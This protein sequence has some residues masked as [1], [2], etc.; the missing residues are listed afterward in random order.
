[1]A[2]DIDG[3]R[4]EE[5]PASQSQFARAVPIYETFPGWDEDIAKA[6]SLDDLPRTARA[7]VAAL[8][9]MIRAPISAVGV[10]PGRDEIV[11]V[12]DLLG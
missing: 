11:T 1:V 12:R 5:L 7:Y 10:G 6:R 9:D 4:H 2:Y 8:E 3:A